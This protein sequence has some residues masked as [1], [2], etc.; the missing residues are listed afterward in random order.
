MTFPRRT[1]HTGTTSRNM[2]CVLTGV[3]ADV[4]QRKSHCGGILKQGQELCD[5]SFLSQEGDRRDQTAVPLKES[6]CSCVHL[7]CFYCSLPA[8]GTIL[9]AKDTALKKTVKN[10][11]FPLAPVFISTAGYMGVQ[12]HILFTFICV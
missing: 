2:P 6:P 3:G 11:C 10:A 4:V 9:S 12:Y 8:A 7:A 5:P 1:D